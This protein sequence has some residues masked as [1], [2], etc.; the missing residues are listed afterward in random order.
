MVREDFL[1]YVWKF[2]MFNSEY[3]NYKGEKIEVIEPGQYNYSSGPDFFNAK[4]K[5]GRTV[6][7]G[8]VEIHVK[9][10]DWFRHGHHKDPAYDNII[11]HMVMDED[12][13]VLRQSGEEIP[14]CRLVI[15]SEILKKYESL[16]N[17]SEEKEC[18]RTL[19]GWDSHL[20]RDWIGKLGFI[21][22]ERKVSQLDAILNENHFD[23]EDAL[24]HMIASSFGMKLNAEPFRMLSRSVPLSF[25]LKNR[26][27]HI[28]LLAAFF[29]Q[30][31]F[32]ESRVNESGYFKKISR[33]Y[34]A[35]GTLL[36]EPILRAHLWKKMRSR[37][38]GF[39]EIRIIQLVEFLRYQL[40]VFERIKSGIKINDL[41]NLFLGPLISLK[42]TM[43]DSTN[44]W[45][46]FHLPTRQT[47][48]SW[49][50][51]GI[52]PVLFRYGQFHKDQGI[53]QSV[54]DILEELPPE[55]NEILKKWNKFGIYPENAFDSQAL[56]ELKT[57][58]CSKL[59]CTECMLGH[60]L[61]SNAGK[62]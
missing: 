30:A 10:S 28:T 46:S 51:N 47:V 37:P 15:Y 57:Q 4:I 14:Q 34:D 55:K 43:L 13:F 61:M 52:I 35:I 29:G 50:I 7:A 25:I 54:I 20:Y 62:K 40:P 11:L 41:R 1:H 44:I 38:T 56:I 23:W 48:D 6:W 21:R 49:I 53:I 12:D 45:L 24:Y 59:A 32:L 9:A 8:N 16:V 60:V 39:P 27:K 3:L 33:E 22:L 17:G 5:I 58:F 36:P 18:Y 19:S 26:E 31:G 2:R 42:K